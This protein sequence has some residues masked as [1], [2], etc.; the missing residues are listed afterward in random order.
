M[1]F[2]FITCVFSALEINRNQFE[3]LIVNGTGKMPIFVMFTSPDCPSCESAEMSFNDAYDEIND[4]VKFVKFDISKDQDFAEEFEITSLPTFVFFFK[5]TPVPYEG[6][7]TINAFKAFV[8]DCVELLLPKV[9]DSWID[10]D[11]DRVILFTHRRL[12][13]KMLVHAYGKYHRR[14]I[15]F[16]MTGNKTFAKAFPGV[17]FPSWWF[18]KGKTGKMEYKGVNQ[19]L[20]LNRA[21]EK[22][23]GVEPSKVGPKKATKPK[24]T[25]YDDL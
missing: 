6:R 21:I 17:K 2:A 3:K 5:N 15:N 12:V 18:F 23:F 22:F 8:T 24:E 9:D 7:R 1:L 14:D 11:E 25:A 20:Q 16:A 10:T 4:T 19:Q 13:P